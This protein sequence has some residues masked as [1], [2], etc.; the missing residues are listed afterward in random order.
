MKLPTCASQT[1]CAV[2]CRSSV[3]IHSLLHFLYLLG[4]SIVEEYLVLSVVLNSW[5]HLS[6]AISILRNICLRWFVL[7]SYQVPES[8]PCP[9]LQPL[10]FQMTG[11]NGH[12][13]GALE[14][15]ALNLSSDL[16]NIKFPTRCKRSSDS[17]TCQ[18]SLKIGSWS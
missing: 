14:L 3:W 18:V 4:G 10:Q 12:T 15:N 9:D 16:D 2:L 7:S 11:A 17:F 6:S 5:K 1:S 8:V 13:S